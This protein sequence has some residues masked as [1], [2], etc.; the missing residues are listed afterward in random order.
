MKC[1]ECDKAFYMDDLSTVDQFVYRCEATKELIVSVDSE[2]CSKAF[3]TK[4]PNDT[5]E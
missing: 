3:R 5:G 4:G 2:G 1:I